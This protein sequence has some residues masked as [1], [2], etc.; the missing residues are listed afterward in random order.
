MAVAISA[1]ATRRPGSTTATSRGISAAVVVTSSCVRTEIDLDR[2]LRPDRQAI[3]DI[4]HVDTAI[5]RRG[6]GIEKRYFQVTVLRHGVAERNADDTAAAFAVEDDGGDGAVVDL[7]F[8]IAPRLM[9]ADIV[10]HQH[11]SLAVTSP[12]CGSGTKSSRW[13]PRLAKRTPLTK[14]I[15]ASVTSASGPRGRGAA[16]AG[17]A[18]AG[19]AELTGG[20]AETRC[21]ACPGRGSGSG[22]RCCASAWMETQSTIAKPHATQ[23][24]IPRPLNPA[25]PSDR[26]KSSA[27]RAPW[28][29]EDRGAVLEAPQSHCR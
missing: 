24:R 27:F 8:K 19:I 18:V 22:K 25:S 1:C 13:P 23:I 14:P 2:A 7:D 29:R 28:R 4:A 17:I 16:G 21:G 11:Q 9:R 12:R 20:S 5:E 10:E 26:D 15:S 3:A 6:A